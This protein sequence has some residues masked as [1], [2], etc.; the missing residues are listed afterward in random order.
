MKARIRNKILNIINTILYTSS[1]RGMASP[2]YAKKYGAKWHK[3]FDKKENVR[4][5]PIFLGKRR[6]DLTARL[7]TEFPE[8]GVIEIENTLLFGRDGFIITKEGFLL[9]DHSWFGY[10]TNEIKTLPRLLL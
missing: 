3:I 2:V 4:L 6:V 10:H 7:E 5:A 8:M 9:S 1:I